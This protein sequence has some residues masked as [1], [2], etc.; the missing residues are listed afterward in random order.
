MKKSYVPASGDIV[1]LEFDPQ[2]GREQAGRRPALVLSPKSYN[3]M[4]GLAVVCPI[5][6]RIKGYPFEVEIQTEKISGA[7]LADHVKSVD[8]A[9]RHATLVDTACQDVVLE[10]VAKLDALLPKAP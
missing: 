9:S 2:V 7:V 3:R 1:W 8:W 6:S 5:T 10:V 4:I